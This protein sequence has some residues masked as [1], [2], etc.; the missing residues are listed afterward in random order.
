MR[1]HEADPWGLVSSAERRWAAALPNRA[2]ASRSRPARR[3]TS[4]P[5]AQT[6]LDGHGFFGTLRVLGQVRSML[7]VC[8][9]RDA[10]YVIDQHAA[11]ERVRFD[12]LRRA[13]AERDVK[14]QRLLFPER[15]ECTEVEAAICE[16]QAEELAHAR[17]RVLAARP[18]HDRRAHGAGAALRAPRPS[19]CSATCSRSSSATAGATSRPRS[20]ARSRRWPATARSARAI[21]CRP[22]RPRAP[23]QPR[24]GRATSRGHCPHG[25]PVVHRSARRARAAP[26]AMTGAPGSTEPSDRRHRRADRRRQD[27]ASRSSS[28]GAS[29]ARS[30]APTA[31][32]STASST[33]A[34][35]SPA[36]AE[37]RGVPH[38]LH[39]RARADRDDRR[40]ALR[41]ARRRGDRRGRGARRGA[42]RG[43]RHGPLAARAPARAAPAAGRRPRAARGA[44]TRGWPKR[45]EQ[46][47]ARAPARSRS[48]QRASG[49]HPSDHAARGARARGARADRPRASA[50][51]RR[52]TRSA[53][54]AIARSR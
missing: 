9:G 24:R 8:E 7:L 5:P 14:T 40:G 53:R 45:G 54:R 12:R 39:R 49:V 27:A 20:T 25:R 11:D 1:S 35:A 17:A 34:R 37:L 2:Q 16:G 30:S 38:H 18:G 23:A 26:G 52:R 42:V 36:R 31:C 32:R 28:A 13:Y 29:A 3:R 50:S 10:L 48:A 19:G 41:G 4:Q 46:A 21:R 43:R 15:V 47:L 6:S 33:S 44:G 22:S 51:C